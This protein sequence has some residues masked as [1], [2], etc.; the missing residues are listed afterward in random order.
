VAINAFSYPPC[1][2]RLGM[3]S[4]PAAAVVRRIGRR[5]PAGRRRQILRGI[6]VPD[7]LRLWILDDRAGG[8][9]K[10]RS[11]RAPLVESQFLGDDESKRCDADFIHAKV[12]V[13]V[14]YTSAGDKRSAFVSRIEAAEGIGCGCRTSKDSA[15]LGRF[16]NLL[17]DGRMHEATAWP[18]TTG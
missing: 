5:R 15:P 10:V 1:G 9:A 7:R 13:L 8:A 14:F 6:P 2:A 16:A 11:Q 18:T 4:K 12:L 3:F 17:R